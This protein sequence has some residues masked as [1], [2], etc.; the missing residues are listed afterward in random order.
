MAVQEKIAW[1]KKLEP[2]REVF[3]QDYIFGDE[4][5]TMVIEL[6]SENAVALT[7]LE[8]K[9]HKETKDTEAFLTFENKFGGVEKGNI[10]YGFVTD[11]PRRSALQSAAI[12]A[13]K[14][15][16][17]GQ[18]GCWARVDM[19]YEKTTGR[20][21]V[22]EIRN[23]PAVFY[24]PRNSLGDDLVVEKTFPG[25]QPALFDLML[26]SHHLQ[27]GS[28]SP[29]TELRTT[30]EAAAKVYN[31]FKEHTGISYNVLLEYPYYKALKAFLNGFSFRDDAILDLECGTGIFGRALNECGQSAHI[32][33]IDI[34]KGMV[35]S[36]DIRKFY[37][38]PVI[39]QEIQSYVMNDVHFDH[40]VC[41]ETMQF[42]HPIEFNAVLARMFQIARK[43]VVFTVA[44]YSPAA[45]KRFFQRHKIKQ[46]NLTEAAKRFGVPPG[47]RVLTDERMLSYRSPTTGE[48]CYDLL[49]H[50]E[51]DEGWTPKVPALDPE[52]HLFLEA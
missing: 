46:F 24:P 37:R 18:P 10:T 40:V 27:L 48:E 30:S 44:D 50:F 7:P 1:M 41:L 26:L 17:Q 2:Q 28:S 16:R 20:V 11:E 42:F 33:G 5:S 8:C 23:P 45:I 43:S 3:T 12:A 31:S 14:I 19:R 39:I 21:Y 25:A 22:I 47:W 36:N 38:N 13:F 4:C 29:L 35:D 34:S 15:A 32:T 6:G 51:R 49:M 52:T 9:F